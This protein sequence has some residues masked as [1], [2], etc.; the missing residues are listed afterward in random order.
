MCTRV[1]ACTCSNTCSVCDADTAMSVR[2]AEPADG[3]GFWPHHL[4][5]VER[6]QH[7]LGGGSVIYLVQNISHNSYKMKDN[8]L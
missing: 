8:T 3:A 5:W 1:R 2:Q 6:R 7:K 4:G